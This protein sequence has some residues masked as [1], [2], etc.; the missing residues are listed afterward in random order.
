MKKTIFFLLALALSTTA[1]L[2]QST[3][4]G[5]PTETGVAEIL[6]TPTPGGSATLP[7]PQDFAV[8]DSPSFL[9]IDFQDAQN[10]WGV[11]S[12]DTGYTETHQGSPGYIL[13][14]ADGGTTWLDVTPSELDDVAYNSRLTVLDVNTAWALIPDADFATGTLYRTV[15]GGATWSSNP[16]PFGGADMQFL[17]PLTGRVL[18]DR[19]AGAGSNAVEMFQSSDGGVTWTSVFHNDPSRGGVSDSLPLS[20][21]KNGMTFLDADTGWVTGTRPMDGDIYLFVTHDGGASWAVQPI[22]TPA[23]YESNQYNPFAP[24]FFGQDGFLPLMIYF[25]GGNIEQVFYVT[26]DGGATWTADPENGSQV[27]RPGSY[28]FADALNG[29]S[30]NGGSNFYFTTDG[31][32]NWT[33]MGLT[34]DL[35]DSLSRIDFVSGGTGWALTG[36]F[37]SGQSWLYRT[38]D[39]GATWTQLIP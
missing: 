13:R 25:P 21:I 20:G 17:D 23:G 19:G 14:S 5:T 24:I 31:A 27:V 34:L 30:W 1:C 3:A 22:A 7:L 16:V 6:A 32:Q 38:S 36:P 10:G 28:S 2:K 26:H 37:D 15:D 39:G 33:G 18:A 12:S 8:I 29:Y 35:S 11:A 9:F 4:T